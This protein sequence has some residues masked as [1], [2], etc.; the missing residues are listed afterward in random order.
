MMKRIKDFKLSDDDVSLKPS[1]SKMS[2][3]TVSEACITEVDPGSV[4]QS[5]GVASGAAALG[6]P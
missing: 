3:L 1:R 2:M 6:I 4:T 5:L